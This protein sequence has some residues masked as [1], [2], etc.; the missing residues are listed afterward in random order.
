ML[1]GVRIA[2]EGVT[3]ANPAFDVTPARYIAAIVTEAGIAR[4]PYG[5]ALHDLIRRNPITKSENQAETAE[6]AETSRA[7][8]AS[9]Q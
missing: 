8:L 7:V 1:G 9:K 3:V 4:P 2:P 6:T 5:D